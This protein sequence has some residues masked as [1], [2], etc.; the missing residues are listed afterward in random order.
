MQK[1][2]T[3]YG[4]GLLKELRQYEAQGVS[5]WL[6]GSRCSPARVSDALCVREEI[7]YMRDYVFH[8]GELSELRFNKIKAKK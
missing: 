7:T 1:K 2:R 3:K 4:Y 8:D 5:L 6:E